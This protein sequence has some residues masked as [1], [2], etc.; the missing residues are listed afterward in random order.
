MVDAL[1]EMVGE[2]VHCRCSLWPGLAMNDAHRN[3]QKVICVE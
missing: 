2:P 3:D 1:R